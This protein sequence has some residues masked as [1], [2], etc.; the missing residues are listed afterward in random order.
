MIAGPGL[1][2]MFLTGT[3][4]MFDWVMSLEPNWYSTIFGAM[5]IVGQGLQTLSLMIIALTLLAD[6]HAMQGIVTPTRLRDLGNLLLAFTVLWAYTNYSQFIIMWSGNLAE[7]VPWYLRRS[8]GGWQFIAML[9]MIFHF[10]VPFL[11]LLVR[12]VK[13]RSRLIR[14]LAFGLLVMHLIDLFWVT[15]PAMG[16]HTLGLSWMDPLAVVG[17]GSLWL[18]TYVRLLRRRPLVARNVPDLEALRPKVALIEA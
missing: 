12:D 1:I 6:R 4:A 3:F 15:A 16:Y 8:Q 10:L 7:E 2:A 5:L 9:L 14:M 17:L 11:I 18:A 13:E